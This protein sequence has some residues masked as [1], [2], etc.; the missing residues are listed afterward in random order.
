MKIWPLVRKIPVWGI[1]TNRNANYFPK[2]FTPR[3]LHFDHTLL[4]YR[5][6]NYIFDSQVDKKGMLLSNNL[7]CILFLHLLKIKSDLKL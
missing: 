7:S 5:V 1:S 3:Y 4:D 2:V 6:H